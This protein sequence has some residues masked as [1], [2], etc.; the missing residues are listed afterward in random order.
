MKY[1]YLISIFLA[2]N[3]KNLSAYQ[4]ITIQKDSN[5]QNYQEL[6]L[7]I[8]NSIT[9]EDIISSIEKNIYNINFSNTQ[10]S[11]NVDIDNLSKDLYAKNINHNLFFLNCSLLENFFKFNNNFENCPNFIIQNFE[12]DSYIYLN[13][14]ENYFR[15]HKFSNNINLKSL[16]FKLLDKN[17]SSYQLSIDPSNY[18]KLKY[19]TG[20]EP[21]ILSYEKNKLLLDFENIYDDK[22]I[23]FLVNFF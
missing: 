15:L 4:E 19:F 6:L 14:N 2:F 7:R 12:K 17:K 3:L 23:N 8:N 1:L 16:W 20:L 11:L 5:L 9:E 10:I 21:K 22:Q 13:F 18:K